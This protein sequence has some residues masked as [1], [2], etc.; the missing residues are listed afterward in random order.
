MPKGALSL[1][2]KIVNGLEGYVPRSPKIAAILLASFLSLLNPNHDDNIMRG[3]DV[4][5]NE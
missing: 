4:L 5:L 1:R 3:L 2:R